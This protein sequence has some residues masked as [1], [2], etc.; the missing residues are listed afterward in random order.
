MSIQSTNDLGKRVAERLKLV[1]AETGINRLQL[2]HLIGV[3]STTMGKIL[4]GKA[5]QTWETI[6]R[7]SRIDPLLAPYICGQADE[8]SISR[9]RLNSTIHSLGGKNDK[10]C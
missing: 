1:M 6:D 3:S 7:L 10:S 9:T 8:V 4:A 2:Q 5:G